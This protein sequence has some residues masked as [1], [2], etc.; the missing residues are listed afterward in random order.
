[1]T[2]RAKVVKPAKPLLPEKEKSNITNL[3]RNQ[4]TKVA[5]PQPPPRMAK[6]KKKKK[7]TLPV[8]QMTPP[9]KMD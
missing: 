9:V 8:E 4:K 5:Q 2:N 3:R 1:V 7:M 6:R